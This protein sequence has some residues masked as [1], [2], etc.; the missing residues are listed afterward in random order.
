L[1]VKV[2]KILLDLNRKEEILQSIL[3]KI[4]PNN[5]DSII[6]DVNEMLE[7]FPID[8]VDHLKNVNRTLTTDKSFCKQLVC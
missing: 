8:D 6:H 3:E 5:D 1:N 4:N 2:N 7:G